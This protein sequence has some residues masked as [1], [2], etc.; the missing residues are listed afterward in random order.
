MS[1]TIVTATVAHAQ[2]ASPAASDDIIVTAPPGEQQLIDRHVY[3]VKDNAQAQTESGLQLMRNVPSVTVN[4]DDKI[5][6]L[7]D[8]KVTVL[9]DGHAVIDGSR[10]LKA[11]PAGQIARI[12]VSTNPSAAYSAEGT[13]GT[14]NIITRRRAAPGLAGSATVTRPDFGGVIAKIAPTFSAGPWSAALAL[15]YDGSRARNDVTRE[16]TAADPTDTFSMR[17]HNIYSDNDFTGHAEIG[18]KPGARRGWT[19]SFDHEES[20]IPD[21]TTETTLARGSA[22]FPLL[23]QT[24]EDW[25]YKND[26]ATL[27]YAWSGTRQGESLSISANGGHHHQATDDRD[28]EDFGGS[29]QTTLSLH[30]ETTDSAELK[31][32]YA[33]PF[34]KSDVVSIGGSVRRADK[35]QSDALNATGDHIVALPFG[36]ASVGGT[37]I[38]SAAYATV[39]FPIGKWTMLPGLRIE[40]RRA[41]APDLGP[42]GKRN[43]LFFFPSL[44]VDRALTKRLT[45]ST[46]YT[47][48]IEWPSLAQLSPLIQYYDPLVAERG[49]PAL[50]PQLTD[51]LEIALA[52]KPGKQNITLKLYDRETAHAWLSTAF[53]LPNGVNLNS[54]DNIGTLR[55]LGGELALQGPI[56]SRWRYNLSVNLLAR[57]STL[58]D[59]G[60]IGSQEQFTYNGNAQLEYQDRP[61]GNPGANHLELA[62]QHLSP[63][64]LFQE[65]Q[66]SYTVGS[67]TWT[68]SFTGRLSSVLKLNNLLGGD[69]ASDVIDG[70]GYRDTKHRL[71]DGRRVTASL[72]CRLGKLH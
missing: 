18:F 72:V 38:T 17:R 49:N 8:P 67:L 9:I 64:H 54:T 46:S 10:A 13:A 32:D 4:S 34:G 68:H 26:S 41:D 66:S 65:R 52:Y 42:N 24:H 7:G 1:L 53:L 16:R 55:R 12:E 44:H 2:T 63:V 39:Q 37:W 43:D 20:L 33:H 27:A 69:G 62:A 25:R 48:R 58:F 51:A 5:Q 23:R 29:S 6:L 35:T 28:D 22:L 71:D 21:L 47:R 70:A 30:G 19:L 60:T 45:L 3:L 56:R 61:D 15:T 36:P 57:R 50:R 14:I 31:L 11:L 59:N 40:D